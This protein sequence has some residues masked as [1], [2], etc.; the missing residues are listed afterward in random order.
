MILYMGG[1]SIGVKEQK[2][3]RKKEE[4]TPSHTS[5]NSQMLFHARLFTCYN[6]IIIV[7]ILASLAS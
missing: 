3:K 2:K 7:F 1:L 6:N 4:K 5:S